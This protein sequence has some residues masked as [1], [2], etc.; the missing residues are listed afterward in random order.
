MMNTLVK[1]AENPN[2]QD[3]I[4]KQ[5]FTPVAYLRMEPEKAVNSL[6]NDFYVVNYLGLD[7]PSRS[8]DT[9]YNN[10]LVLSGAGEHHDIPT[11]M[12]EDFLSNEF[13]QKARH[14]P[15]PRKEREI[16]RKIML[17]KIE[18]VHRGQ[19]PLGLDIAQNYSTIFGVLGFPMGAEEIVKYSTHADYFKPIL[20]TDHVDTSVAEIAH[21]V[22]GTAPVIRKWD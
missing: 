13:F 16:I 14:G 20:L 21:H 7:I 19:E 4:S 17:D 10:G 22:V 6:F 12:I 15:F 8:G 18:P 3:F 11:G 9:N 1:Y 5:G 2:P